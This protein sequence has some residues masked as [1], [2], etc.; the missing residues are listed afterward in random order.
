MEHTWHDKADWD[1]IVWYH[2]NR[3]KI[4]SI[5]DKYKYNLDQFAVEFTTQGHPRYYFEFSR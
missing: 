5:V 1:G 2:W 4:D 3:S